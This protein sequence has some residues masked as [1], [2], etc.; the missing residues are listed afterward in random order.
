[1]TTTPPII[2]VVDDNESAREIFANM[3]QAFKFSVDVAAD[4]VQALAAMHA[5][6]AAGTPYAIVVMDWLMPE[7][8]GVHCAARIRTEFP[9]Q[10]QPKIIMVTA[11]DPADLPQ[12]VDEGVAVDEG[13]RGECGEIVVRHA[14]RLPAAASR[15]I[16]HTG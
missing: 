3:L 9:P 14:A 1:M 16:V 11:R 6:Q 13:V 5:A 7:M 10:L 15:R 8:D 12:V 4:G 2:L